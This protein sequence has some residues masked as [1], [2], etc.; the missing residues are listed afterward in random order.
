MSKHEEVGFNRKEIQAE[1][2]LHQAFFSS[3]QHIFLIVCNGST[4]Y[5]H[6]AT[7]ASSVML[8]LI[9][10]SALMCDLY[11]PCPHKIS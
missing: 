2:R 3:G 9:V 1:T 8:V 7:N 10:Y 5:L 4:W 11:F 6:Y